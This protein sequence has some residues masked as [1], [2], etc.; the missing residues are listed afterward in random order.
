MHADRAPEDQDITLQ[1]YLPEGPSIMVCITLAVSS[2][3]GVRMVHGDVGSLIR[4]M[5]G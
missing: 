4:G 5:S 3:V 2:Q 1:L